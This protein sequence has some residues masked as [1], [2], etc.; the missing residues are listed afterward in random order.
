MHTFLKLTFKFSTYHKI[1]TDNGKSTLLTQ[2]LASL[3][4]FFCIFCLFVCLFRESSNAKAILLE[5]PQRYYLT[6]C[7]RDKEVHAFPKGIRK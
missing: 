6:H 2:K 1:F 4:F 7:R 3:D 5:E